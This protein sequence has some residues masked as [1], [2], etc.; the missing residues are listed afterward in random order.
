MAMLTQVLKLDPRNIVKSYYSHKIWNEIK[1]KEPPHHVA[2]ITDGNRRWA[3]ARHLDR[4]KGHEYGI[5]KLKEVLE[6][7]WEAGIEVLTIYAFSNE[8]FSRSEEEVTKLMNLFQE[9]FLALVTAPEIH[10][11]KIRIKVLGKIESLPQEVQE[12]IQK[13]EN[14]T[15]EYNNRLLQI[16]VGY[17]GRVEVVD[18][19]KGILK[20]KIA[21]EEVTEGS[22]EKYLYTRGIKDPDLIIRTSGEER[23]SGFL[24]WQ[25]ANS[26]LYFVKAYF[27][28]FSKVDLWKAIRTYQSHQNS[29][30]SYQ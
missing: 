17:A 14:A 18:A 3:V 27:P 22:V 16:A 24:L 20:D 4:K 10:H 21:P 19:I 2:I 5:E 26:E 29:S 30:L 13:A 8:N 6:W 9:N 12:A 11:Y 15:K 25:S 23:L 1:G 28:S 7:V